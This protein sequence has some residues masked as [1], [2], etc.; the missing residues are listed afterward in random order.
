MITGVNTLFNALL[1]NPEFAKLDFSPLHVSLAGGMA[2]QSPV[3]EKWKQITG[4]AL[5]EAYGLSETSPAGR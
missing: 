5:I 1:N 3:A 4:K 2:V